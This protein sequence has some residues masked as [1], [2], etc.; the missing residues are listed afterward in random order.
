MSALSVS[1]PFNT[2]LD[3]NGESLEAGYIYIGTAGLNPVTNP[4]QAYWDAALTQPAPQPIRTVGGAP[5]RSG[6]PSALYID[7]GDYSILVRNSNMSFVYSALNAAQRISA[8]LITGIQ[9]SQVEYTPAGTSAVATTV[10]KDLNAQEVNVF[11]FM[12]EAEITD[13]QSGSPVL[14]V[15]TAA[16]N[17]IATGKKVR[18]PSGTY[19]LNVVIDNKTILV[20]DGSTETIF[21]PF[22][23]AQ[24]AVTYRAASPFWT[25]HSTVEGIKFQGIGTKTGVGFTFGATTQ[26]GF[27]TDAQFANNVKFKSCLFENLEKGVQ[28]PFGNIGSE[29]YSCGFTANKYGVYSIGNKQGGSIMHAGNKYFYS[30]EFNSNDCAFYL[31]DVTTGFG[32]VAFKDTI[33]E[34]NLMALY[35]YTPACFTPVSFSDVWFEANGQLSSGAATVTVDAWS[36][37]TRSDLV[38]TKKTMIFDGNGDPATYNFDGGFLTDTQLRG[39]GITL[40]SRNSRTEHL[41]GFGGGSFEL[42]SPSTSCVRFLSP[43]TSGGIDIDD[44]IIVADSPIN[45]RFTINSDVPGGVSRL[46]ITKPRSSKVANYGA[47]RAMSSPLTAG[48]TTGNGAFNLTGSV[49]T[50]G[51]IYN[52]CNEF[53]RAGF[54][55]SEFTRLNSPDSLIV[56]TAGWYV[57]TLDFKRT[58]GNPNFFV[59]DRAT[60]NFVLAGQAPTAGLWYT[61]AGIGYSAGGQTLYLDFSGS[62]EDCTWRISAYQIHFFNTRQE[63]ESFLQAGAFAES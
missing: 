54:L 16:S 8:D 23:V 3:L 4:I 26:A 60:A 20:G 6:T 22:N 51:Q 41:L 28:F 33:F 1:P 49:V 42:D 39:N 13:V 30:G 47:S 19:L 52:S 58:L 61:F 40:T 44:G 10:E 2:F 55:S 17:A 31:H 35:M 14:D 56:T 57:F 59:W 11:R 5:S 46:F 36:G 50:D 53:T 9:A 45:T 37:S 34:F 48:A 21:K 38:L 63:A 12:S 29:F 25:Y 43:T 24:A 27:Y 15:T 7:A 32:G 62:N 18:F